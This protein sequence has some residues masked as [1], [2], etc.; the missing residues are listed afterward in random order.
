MTD[1]TINS[2]VSIDGNSGQVAH[3]VPALP[4]GEEIFKGAACRVYDSK[5]YLS[6]SSI[7]ETTGLVSGSM[8]SSRFDGISNN[9]AFQ[10]G[11]PVTLYGVGSIW[12]YGTGL[13]S[14]SRLFIGT[15]SGCLSYT[16]AFEGDLP[17]ARVL[18]SESIKVIR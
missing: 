11:E 6:G 3:Y 8:V 9:S 15:T 10:A 7:T 17:V 1:I 12:G 5:I 18:T 2:T 13:M 16:Q 4:A 14:G